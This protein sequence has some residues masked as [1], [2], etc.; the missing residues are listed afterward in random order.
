MQ[1]YRLDEIDETLLALLCIDG[2]T[3]FAEMAHAV[4]L[5]PDAARARYLRMTTDGVLRVIGVVSPQSLGY[6]RLAN[7]WMSYRGSMES[8]A[9]LGSATRHVT[10]M[11]QLLGRYNVLAEIAARDDTEVADIV[12][13]AFLS[14]PE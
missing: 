9:K 7:V 3:P 8:M 14:V 2:R 1:R 11:T 4:G 5:S 6:G 12:T 10:F 13:S